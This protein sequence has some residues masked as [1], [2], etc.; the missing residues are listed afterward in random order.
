MVEI[1]CSIAVGVE[2]IGSFFIIYY[3]MYEKVAGHNVRDVH[4]ERSG[5]SGQ[6]GI[7]LNSA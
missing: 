2:M 5:R 6:L 7:I 3:L 1:S 4:A